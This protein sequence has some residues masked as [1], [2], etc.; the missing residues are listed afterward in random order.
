MCTFCNISLRFQSCSPMVHLLD[1][2]PEHVFIII[3]MI[4]NLL[5]L[6]P[7][8]Y[9][10]ST[11]RELHHDRVS[12]RRFSQLWG[13]VKHSYSILLLNVLTLLASARPAQTTRNR[14]SKSWF[15]T[16]TRVASETT[17]NVDQHPSNSDVLSTA[18]CWESVQT[19]L[20][21]SCES[22]FASVNHVGFDSALH[23]RVESPLVRYPSRLGISLASGYMGAR[24]HFPV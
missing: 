17:P 7:Y 21:V 23:C 6:N 4:D 13:R 2:V 19:V 12:S 22:P 3:C 10:Q 8:R 14:S 1:L 24:R 5:N 11:R 20:T 15:S 16:S 9:R 18:G